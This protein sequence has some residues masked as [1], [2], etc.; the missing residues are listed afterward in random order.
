MGNHGS[1]SSPCSLLQGFLLMAEVRCV[2]PPGGEKRGSF[3]EGALW[4]ERHHKTT[5]VLFGSGCFPNPSEK[6]CLNQIGSFP[7]KSRG[8]HSKKLFELPPPSH[9]QS[10]KE[11]QQN[12]KHL[13][14]WRVFFQQVQPILIPWLT[15]FPDV[16]HIMFA[17]RHH[18]Y[19]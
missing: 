14:S 19:W 17:S 9:K 5:R 13:E 16:P 12:S 15:T 3:E 18:G 11:H 1:S 2:N 10:P 7:Q 6:L 4:S 8:E